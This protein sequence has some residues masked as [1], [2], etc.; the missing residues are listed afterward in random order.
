MTFESGNAVFGRASNPHNRT[1]TPGGSSGGE[2]ALVAF[3]GSHLGIGTDIG[4]SVRIPSFFAGTYGLKPS[5]G[6]VT[7][8]Q[9]PHNGTIIGVI[10]GSGINAVQGPLARSVQDLEVYMKTE[11][12]SEE[13]RHDADIVPIPWRHVELPKKLKLG[14]FFSTGI[15]QLPSSI[16]RVVKFAVDKMKEAGHE[17]VEFPTPMAPEM[18]GLW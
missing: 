2:G 16:E 7:R 14:Y 6:R 18:L 3:C 17:L 15:A 8:R 1:L 10:G 11:V 12:D 9:I 13:W 4:G 5:F